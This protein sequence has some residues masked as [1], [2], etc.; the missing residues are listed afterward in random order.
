MS[1]RPSG[2][3]RRALRTVGVVAG[4]G[5]LVAA[6]GP[7]IH[8]GERA[9]AVDRGSGGAEPAS[10]G[11]VYVPGRILVRFQEATPPGE[12]E[13]VL[14]RA[15][16]ESAAVIPRLDVHVVD[17]GA[18]PES[19]AIAALGRSPWVE[20]AERDLVVEAFDRIPNDARWPEQWGARTIRAPRAW[21]ATVGSAGVV[22]AV[23][24]TGIAPEHPDMRGALVPGFDFVNNDA[25]ASDDHGHGTSA[26]GVA[27]AR[28]NNL[29]G[30]AGICW[31]CKL[32]PVK[33]LGSNGSGTTSS[34]AAGITWATANGADVV[35][36]SLGGAGTT[37]TLTD[38]VVDAAAKGV[39]VVAAA[40][41]EA[42]TV[43][44][45][46]AAYE[47][48]IAVAGTDAAD[49]LYSWSNRGSWVD[50]A[51]PGCNVAPVFSGGYGSFCG[52]SSATPV[53]AGLAGLLLAARPSS[54][55]ADVRAAIEETAVAI[56]PDVRRGRIDAAA[57]VGRFAVFPP[58]PA[59]PLP[60]APPSPPPPAS[61]PTPRPEEPGSEALAPAAAAT[62]PRGAFQRDR[63]ITVRWSAPGAASYDVRVRAA[64][65]DAR[66]GAALLAAAGTASQS[67][68]MVG[69]PGWTYCFSVLARS[70]D[71]ATAASGPEA[72]TAVPLDE[73]GLRRSG[74]WRARRSATAYLGTEL[75]AS[76]RGAA[77]AGRVSARRVAVV[78]TR[79]PGC[80][81]L[82]VSF[83]G[84]ALRTLS[85][86]AARLRRNQIVPVARFGAVR[87]GTLRLEVV[88]AG[89]PVRVEGLG[90][91][92]R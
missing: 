90:V 64:G 22:V 56:G 71:G 62:T 4:L 31:E 83:R 65:R 24:D 86:N 34:V 32:M 20:Y 78:V 43:P 50:V 25:D 48:V 3:G 42:S 45:Y 79:C 92:A 6:V 19:E 85:L 35:T 47:D 36:M 12:V 18:R 81:R 58:P 68:D 61:P 88:S 46:P 55:A 53:V 89:R 57:A 8:R 77:L 38:A 44:S 66:F 91:S 63:T 75:V 54:T 14:A 52:T 28:S 60:P 70:V 23:L 67:L 49:R 39:V 5:V 37:K 76:R 11:V 80:G 10:A 27:S 30:V 16:V 33:V 72:C 26:A 2:L 59:S 21:D 41:N 17:V 40:G 74:I 9:E 51:A 73:R 87:R 1:E 69:R 7:S 13:A 84:R 15:G 82:R 29:E